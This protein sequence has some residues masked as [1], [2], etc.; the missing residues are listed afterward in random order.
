MKWYNKKKTE[1]VNLDFIAGFEYNSDVNML[2]LF[3][4]G[5]TFKFYTEEASEIYDLL[6]SENKKQLLT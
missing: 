6:I 2:T 1:M 4:N 5:S 3:I